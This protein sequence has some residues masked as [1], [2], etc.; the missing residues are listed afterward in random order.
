MNDPNKNKIKQ[1]SSYSFIW[2]REG[3]DDPSSN[4]L[5]SL[6]NKRAKLVY[7]ELGDLFSACF[8]E[9]YK[10][11]NIYNALLDFTRHTPRDFIEL[12]NYIK[13]QC[14]SGIVSTTD[15]TNGVNE[16]SLEYF[17]QEIKD[18]M[19]GYI[20]NEECNALIK[21]LSSLQKRDFYLN[22]L[23]PLYSKYYPNDTHDVLV[24]NLKVLYEC[25]AIGHIYSYGKRVKIT[26]KYRN[27]NSSFTEKDR[28]FLHKGL[29]KSL[30][31]NY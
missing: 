29:W 30:N 23:E 21:C 8:P 15:I 13:K 10:K 19:A 4:P 20:P 27:R 18:E 1:D 2:Y 16:Y 6:A 11:A 31:V 9:E 28:I 22:E 17:V 12:L 5:V 14:T 26:F 25:S 7:P 3:V 24:K